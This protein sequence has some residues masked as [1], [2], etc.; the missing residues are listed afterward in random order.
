L[1]CAHQNVLIFHQLPEIR[2]SFREKEEGKFGKQS[3]RSLCISGE[4]YC[5][6]TLLS[7]FGD[8]T[9]RDK[10]GKAFYRFEIT[11]TVKE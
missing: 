3:V 11:A 4:V 9:K 2:E 10:A 6:L 5:I 8:T 1:T 7:R